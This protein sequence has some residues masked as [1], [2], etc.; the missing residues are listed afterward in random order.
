[1]QHLNNYLNNID[2]RGIGN[3]NTACF[4]FSKTFFLFKIFRKQSR[5]QSLALQYDPPALG[6]ALRGGE[7]RHSC[8]VLACGCSCGFV[9]GRWLPRMSCGTRLTGVV[10]FAWGITSVMVACIQHAQ[11]I[12]NWII[13]LTV[14]FTCPFQSKAAVMLRFEHITFF[15]CALGCLTHHDKCLPGLTWQGIQT[16]VAWSGLRQ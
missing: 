10:A 14:C 7:Q 12:N 13:A 2:F 15:P 9:V 5:P 4:A 6:K 11:A 1:M 16:R 8:P 3:G